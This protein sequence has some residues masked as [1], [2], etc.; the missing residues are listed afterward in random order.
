[1]AIFYPP[2]N[3]VGMIGGFVNHD[4]ITKYTVRS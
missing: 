4:H 3:E 1:M 2:L